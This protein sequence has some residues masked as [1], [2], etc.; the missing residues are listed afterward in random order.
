[1]NR[2]ELLQLAERVERA[3]AAEQRAM[4]EE[5]WLAIHHE[6]YPPED[7][8]DTCRKCDRFDKLLEAE[9]YESAALMLV[10]EGWVVGSLEWWSMRHDAGVTLL[11]TG[12]TDDGFQGYSAAVHGDARAKAVTPALALCAASLKALASQ[13][14]GEKAGGGRG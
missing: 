14:G 1:M 6:G 11:E 13:I 7:A 5:A 9:A 10:P 12:P 3:E 4:L 8:S 2:D